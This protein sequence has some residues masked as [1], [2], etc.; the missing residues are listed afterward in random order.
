M[1]VVGTEHFLVNRE[2]ALQERLSVGIALLAAV[3]RGE[4]AEAFADIG[5]VRAERLLVNRER[6]L[7]ERLCR[8]I[9]ALDEM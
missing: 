2:R 3:E 6:A 7:D 5:M 8:G 4:I 9:A 1:G